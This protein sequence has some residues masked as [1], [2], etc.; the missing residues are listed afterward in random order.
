MRGHREAR[1][2]DEIRA[3]LRRAAGQIQALERMVEEERY[4][5][6]LLTQLSAVRGA[7]HEVAL[8]L[9]RRHLGTCVTQVMRSGRPEAR[10]RAVDEILSVLDR[11]RR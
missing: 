6:D 8:I 3:R 2:K 11:V 9:L 5:L 1:E 10:E 4:C 7:L